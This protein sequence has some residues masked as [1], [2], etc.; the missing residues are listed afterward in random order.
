MKLWAKILIGLAVGVVVGLIAG[1]RA[2]YLRPIG[3]IFLRLINMLVIPL[4]FASMTVGITSI[5]DP[6]KLGRVGGKSLFLYLITTAVAICIGL[7]FAYLFKPGQ[8]I[9]FQAPADLKLQSPPALSEILLNIIPSNPIA[10]LAEGQVLQVIVFSI[11][12][13]LAIN[14]AGEKGRP[15]VRVLQSL[16]DVMY[17]LTSIVMEFAPYGVFAIMAWVVGTFGWSILLRLALFLGTNYISCL[18]QVVFIFGGMIWLWAR[19]NPLPFL[20][21][22]GDA[23]ALAFSTSSSSATLPVSMHCVRENLGVSQSMTNFILPLGSTINMNGT[24]IFQA[25]SAVFVAQ[26]YGIDLNWIQVVTI[27]VTATISAIGAAGIPGTGYVMLTLV[28]SSVGLPTEGM[29]IIFGVDRLREMVSTVVNI[30]GDAVVAV[31]IAKSEGELDVD[32]YNLAELV[33][34]EESEV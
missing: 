14:L 11:F 20:K 9:G 34:F 1:E 26:A 6:R 19:L 16:A 3:T 15:L 28:L 7:G 25:V 4:V 10:S 24:A 5:H 12:L 29:A 8:G 18:V 31:L 23:M 32:Q 17:R 27:V 22:M 21:G 30:L 13:G 2:V 33:G